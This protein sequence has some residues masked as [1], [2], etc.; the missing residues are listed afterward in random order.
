MFQYLGRHLY[1]T[2]YYWTAVW[3]KIMRARSVWGKLGT[4][5]QRERADPR[6]A[7]MF[8]RAVVQLILLYGSET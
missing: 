8:C 1:Q 6:L 5:I 7:E 2:D 4:L 3:R